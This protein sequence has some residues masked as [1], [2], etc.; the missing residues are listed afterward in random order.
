MP[1]DRQPRR[2]TQ[3]P[4][5]TGCRRQGIQIL[6]PE[7]LLVP[8]TPKLTVSQRFYRH[9]AMIHDRAFVVEV[10]VAGLFISTFEM[11]GRFCNNDQSFAAEPAA[12]SASWS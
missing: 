2:I 8:R 4:E 3:T 9:T 5:Q 10:G 11:R 12:R 1:Q 6:G 7:R